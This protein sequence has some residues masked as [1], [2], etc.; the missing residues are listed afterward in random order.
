MPGEVEPG[1]V[2]LAVAL[3]AGE[4]AALDAGGERLVAETGELGRFEQ[5]VLDR[6]VVGVAG[7]RPPDV[8]LGGADDLVDRLPGDFEDVV[9]DGGVDAVEGADGV[10]ELAGYLVPGVGAALGPLSMKDDRRLRC[11]GS[12]RAGRRRGRRSWGG[13]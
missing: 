5:V 13:P 4:A 7:Q 3:D 8:A 10:T 2:V 9:G 6:L 12:R 11:G 1:D